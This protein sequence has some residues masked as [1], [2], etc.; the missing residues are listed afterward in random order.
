MEDKIIL[1]NC[2]LLPR[3]RMHVHVYI[4]IENRWIKSQTLQYVFHIPLKIKNTVPSKNIQ[5]LQNQLTSLLKHVELRQTTRSIS[6][7][8][9]KVFHSDK[10]SIQEFLKFQFLHLILTEIE[11]IE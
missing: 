11:T 7:S 8:I 2:N 5:L 10:P 1:Q 9:S 3:V 6:K 4:H